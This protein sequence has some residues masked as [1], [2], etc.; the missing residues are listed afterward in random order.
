MQRADLR[1][2]FQRGGRLENRVGNVAGIRRHRSHVMAG[3]RVLRHQWQSQQKKTWKGKQ[4]RSAHQMILGRTMIITSWAAAKD[5][6]FELLLG[7]AILLKAPVAKTV[8][9]ISPAQ[10]I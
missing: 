1:R 8:L 10:I 7:F 3:V 5:V 6:A 9:P 4:L 2:R